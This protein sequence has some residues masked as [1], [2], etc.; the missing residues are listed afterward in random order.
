[1]FESY[2][3][4]LVNFEDL[5]NFTIIESPFLL[6]VTM[7]GVPFEFLI[8]RKNDS[9]NLLV[10]GSGAYNPEKQKPPIFQ[11][12][13]WMDDFQESV[14][15][16][17]DPT[18]Y[19]GE[20]NLGWGYGTHERH[21]LEELSLILSKIITKLEYKN[22]NVSFYGSSAG[23]FMSMMLACSIKGSIAVVNNP[24][25]IVS[26]YAK[27]HVRRLYGT[28]YKDGSNDFSSFI[29]H[30]VNV[31]EFFK[32]KQYI[33]TIFYAQNL[34]CDHDVNNHLT[35]FIK[36]IG[37]VD[38]SLLKSKI[39]MQYYLNTEQGHNPMAKKDTLEFIKNSIKQF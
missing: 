33:P 23:G 15:F 18:L 13:T 22:E 29:K 8:N 38:D 7:E 21:Y 28:V 6:T 2:R 39:T 5:D 34:A 4:S 24:Q 10:L 35:P 32:D 16:Y 30:R 37:E 12:Y 27:K 9:D 17:N 14:I 19:L 36:Q 20:M 3:R 31:V 11:R 1:M 25:T 26:N